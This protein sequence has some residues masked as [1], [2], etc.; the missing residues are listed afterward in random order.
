MSIFD[1]KKLHGLYGRE[2]LKQKD[3]YEYHVRYGEITDDR[4][5]RSDNAP[6]FYDYDENDPLVRDLGRIFND[7]NIR[8]YKKD[9][10]E[11]LIFIKND[12]EV[13]AGF[14][15]G[16]MKPEDKGLTYF[17][18]DHIFNGKRIAPFLKPDPAYD[19]FMHF[20]Y[21]RDVFFID[22]E[23][24][25]EAL[26]ETGPVMGEDCLPDENGAWDRAF[27]ELLFLHYFMEKGL[28]RHVEK[29]ALHIRIRE[30]DIRGYEEEDDDAKKSPERAIHRMY[31][32]KHRAKDILRAHEK[33]RAKAGYAK[34]MEEYRVSVIIPSKDNSSLMKKCLEG[35]LNIAEK[36]R[37]K[38]Q[39][40]TV[41]NGS[42]EEERIK[43][44]ED[45]EKF[46]YENALKNRDSFAEYIY[47][48]MEFNFSRMCN[49]GA[50]RAC[51]EIL[52][53]MND[54]IEFSDD[55]PFISM[56]RYAMMKDAGAVGIKL[57]YPDSGLIQHCGITD[58]DCGPSHKLQ[59]HDDGKIWY[60]GINRINR[61]TL[62]VTGAC[63]A[64]TREKYFNVSG[65]NDKMKVG[66]NDVDLCLKLHEYGYRNIILNEVFLYHHE[67]LTRGRDSKDDAKY[68]RL[69]MERSLLYRDH[70]WLRTDGD[71]FYNSRLITDTLDYDINVIPEYM[72]RSTRSIVSEIPPR[73]LKKIE[74]F[75]SGRLKFNIES[76]SFERAVNTEE[77]DHYVI[78]GWCVMDKR[79]N[80]VYLK[81]LILIPGKKDGED[82]RET[83]GEQGHVPALRVSLF[84]K[85]R[86]DVS[87]V[88]KDSKRSE[89][90]GFAAKI[91][92]N[93][94]REDVSYLPAVE[95]TSFLT[96]KRNMSSDTGDVNIRNVV[97]GK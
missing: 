60:F 83:S 85:Y 19:T 45:I 26:E 35:F 13:S 58:L 25:L 10:K 15:T 53:F 47:E 77:D 72:K 49:I 54:D 61:N 80:S 76:V 93:T 23:T 20:N 91:P 81:E 29:T 3:P 17:D 88:F 70:R 78:E 67:S 46:N 5:I 34:D 24:A 90:S 94:V 31:Y 12:S 22:R 73:E 51:Y 56:F 38:L 21:I 27:A 9:G 57:L 2:L 74:R 32:E 96:G 59:F 33:L 36:G 18:H 1:T 37:I 39:I 66:Y 82:G 65:F 16:A 86:E 28:V 92:C 42:R 68:Q 84:P 71:P 44:T 89:L 97:F 75:S 95:M 64:V 62:A 11:Y 40:I 43:I 30:E 52:L 6:L 50:D 63:L 7:L 14:I 69:Q 79:D 48:P 8:G 87:L 41:D 55:E 4:G